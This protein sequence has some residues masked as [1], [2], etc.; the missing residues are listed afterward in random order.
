ME[1]PKPLSRK[2]LNA[3]HRARLAGATCLCYLETLKS[4]LMYIF[5]VKIT[6]MSKE[7][8]CLLSP[9]LRKTRA[10][11]KDRGEG[12]GRSVETTACYYILPDNNRAEGQVISPVSQ[13]LYLLNVSV[14]RPSSHIYARLSSTCHLFFQLSP[15]PIT[16]N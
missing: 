16:T 7:I 3:T 14:Y 11:N 1:R 2:T 13:I 10:K 9:I 15:L 8:K 12:R 6:F 4:E 5:P